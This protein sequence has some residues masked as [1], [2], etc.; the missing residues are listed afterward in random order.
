M[1]KILMILLGVFLMSVC[2]QAQEERLLFVEQRAALAA[3]ERFLFVQLKQAVKNKDTDSLKKLL[4][5]TNSRVWT[6]KDKH[7]NNL[8]PH[9]VFLFHL[10]KLL[11][12]YF[13]PHLH[14]LQH[15]AY[16]RLL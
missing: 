2:A 11:I 16:L 13:L 15:P 10:G 14:P 4:K 12:K 7:G 9:Q 6:Q 3:Y 8:F 1:K 5:K